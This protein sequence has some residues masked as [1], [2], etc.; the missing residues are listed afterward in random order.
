MSTAWL[1]GGTGHAFLLNV[2]ES[3]SAAGPTAWHTERLFQLGYNLGYAVQGVCAFRHGKEF[4]EQQKVAWEQ[5]KRA[6]AQGLPCYGFDL[7][8]PEYYVVYGC[9][10]E[11][12]LYRGVSEGRKPW[13]ELGGS[14]IGLLEMYWVERC[15]GADDRAVVQE[16]LEF[17]LEFAKS[18]RK[19]IMPGY[20]AGLD[21]YDA[22]IRALESGRADG[23]GMA[24]NAAVWAECR[25]L[26]VPFL[27]EAAERIGGAV[28]AL[29]REA[30]GRYAAVRE[31]L[32]AVFALF[33]FHER[34]PE[35]IR[36]VKRC[37]QA[38]GHLR[39]AREAE[40]A[41]LEVLRRLYQSL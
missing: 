3:V 29:A 34:E 8:I 6:L 18:P 22:W 32:R 15:E 5:T 40:A 16:A 23:F 1:Y 31:E 4:A 30:A 37:A 24:Y 7:E 39:R 27:E 28:A 12:Y 17:A 25:E 21:G 19:W 35:Q 14:E 9:E 13:Q 33:P 20:A 11:A 10:E 2:Q 41:G 38:V 26:A 36:D